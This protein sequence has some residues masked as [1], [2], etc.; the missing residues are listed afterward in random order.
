MSWTRKADLLQ[1]TQSHACVAIAGKV[2]IFGGS[3]AGATR[4]CAE[5]DPTT[6]TWA[7]KADIP[8][9]ARYVLAGAAVN[10][11]AYALGGLDAGLTELAD[12]DEYDPVANAWT[13]RADMTPARQGPSAAGISGKVYVVGGYS[14]FTPLRDCDEFDP[15]LNT[16]ASMADMP[17][18]AR[19]G[20]AAAVVS[21]QLFVFGGNDGPTEI[22]DCDSYDPSTNNWTSWADMPAPGRRQPA[23]V[24]IGGLIYIFGGFNRTLV[25][26]NRYL[27]DCD[28]Y[29]PSTDSW[30]S[31]ADILA[32]GRYVLGA[33]TVGGDAYITGGRGAIG[34]LPYT[35]QGVFVTPTMIAIN[36]SY[37]L[38]REEL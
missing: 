12:C 15:I 11:K 4:A 14:A 29:N 24:A 7:A 18:P 28:R 19:S 1:A 37:A 32:P 6:D 21:N 13:P 22:Q 27:R 10:G 20:A 30:T 3:V 17:L 2:Y 23:A 31:E 5:Y 26:D 33:A 9:P 25:G 34:T 8:L 36:K 38:A 35:D 16:W